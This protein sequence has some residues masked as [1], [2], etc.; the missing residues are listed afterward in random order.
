M[1]T[2]PRVIGNDYATDLGNTLRYYQQMHE[3]YS[4]VDNKDEEYFALLTDNLE[5]LKQQWQAYLDMLSVKKQGC[6]F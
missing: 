4:N 5:W 6:F 1:F 2:V 3:A